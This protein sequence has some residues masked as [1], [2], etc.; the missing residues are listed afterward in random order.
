MSWYGDAW[1][2]LGSPIS[3][4]GK[5]VSP[6]EV[7]L[8]TALTLANGLFSDDPQED[9]T[10]TESYAQYMA[11]QTAANQAAELAANKE[12]LMAKLAAEKEMAAAQ[13][14]AMIKSAKIGATSNA[15]SATSR[16]MADIL[17]EKLKA[18]RGIPE[19]LQRAGENITNAYLQ[20]GA[21]GQKG[22][23]DIASNLA[24]YRSR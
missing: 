11:G 7:F 18:R 20:R 12:M 8:P 19:V 1:D 22:F 6:I 16:A 2:W 13:A 5:G 3:S 21:L 15:Y 4:S 9:Y 10:R 24:A 14:A 17:A 23:S